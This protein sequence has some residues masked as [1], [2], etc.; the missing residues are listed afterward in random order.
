MTPRPANSA[1][2]LRRLPVVL[3]ILVVVVS[4]AFHVLAVRP[5]ERRLASLEAALASRTPVVAV[6]PTSI[7]AQSEIAARLGHF[8]AFFDSELS[9]ADWLARFYDAAE[10]TGVMTQRVEYRTT[11]PAGIPLV[12]HELSVPVTGDSSKIRSFCETVLSSIPVVSLDQ[13]TFRRPR[14][15]DAEVEADL[16]F[17][18]YLPKQ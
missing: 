3:A 4:A 10:R 15:T 16:R 5:A 14:A 8:Y 7:S 13:I 17:T 18:F 9:Y 11:E 1:G 6:R 12:L 2:G